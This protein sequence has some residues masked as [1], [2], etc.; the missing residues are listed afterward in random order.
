MTDKLWVIVADSARARIF[1]AE[2]RT[3]PL[4]EI[5]SLEHPEGRMHAIDLTSDLP[6]KDSDRTGLGR[7]AIN[8][9][10]PKQTEA[11]NFARK[12]AEILEA[13]RVSKKFRQLVIIAP[14]SFLGILRDLIGTQLARLVTCE[15][16]KN[17]TQIEAAA[18]RETLSDHLSPVST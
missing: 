16:D 14:P 3:A 10:D 13:A 12:I 15:L 18:I 6:G 5:K 8:Y 9:S 17:L 7:H 1:S 2:T 11:V 4:I